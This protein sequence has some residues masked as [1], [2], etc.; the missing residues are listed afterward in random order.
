MKGR[1][2]LLEKKDDNNNYQPITVF[3]DIDAVIFL[4]RG[5]S[6][7]SNIPSKIEVKQKESGVVFIRTSLQDVGGIGDLTG[8]LGGRIRIPV[9]IKKGPRDK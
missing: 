8:L 6:V 9:L 5:V 2:Y 4:A 7:L 3:K 1:E